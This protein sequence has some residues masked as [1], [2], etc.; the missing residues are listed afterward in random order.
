M[1]NDDVVKQL[2]G[3]KYQVMPPLSQSAQDGLE[4]SIRRLQRLLYPIV[5]DEDGNLLDGH[6]RLYFWHKLKR[7]GMDLE[8]YQVIIVR[9]LSE[10]EKRAYARNLNL[11]RR[12]LSQ[13]ERRELIAQQIKE[14]P[15]KSDRQIAAALGCDHKTVASVREE[16]EGRGEIPHVE[17]RTDSRGRSQPAR[18]PMVFAKNRAEERRARKVL[19]AVPVDSWPDQVIDSRQATRLG[20]KY[21]LDNPPEVPAV[22]TI[23]EAT[24]YHGDL[25]EALSGVPDNSVNLIFCDPP[26]DKE[27]IPV[28]GYLSQLASRILRDDGVLVAYS[29][30]IYLPDIILELGRHMKYHWQLN[31]VH[32]GGSTL[33]NSRFIRSRG[34]PI[35]MYVKKDSNRREKWIDD[36]VKGAGMEKGLHEW[37]QGEPEAMHLIEKLTDPGNLVVDP[38]V[39][40]GTTAA[41]AV[42]LGRRFIG[43]D[44]NPGAVAI[45]QERLAALTREESA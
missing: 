33:V 18:K 22:Q 19:Q 42:R 5:T 31:L 24:L 27:S 38:F 36:L 13:E 26:Y 21:R 20:R 45:T 14:D 43:C 2:P 35:F 28:Y 30:K 9:G 23:G 6:W 1:M 39:G 7:E 40:S 25:L 44:I 32:G 37:Q 11:A 29:G 15:R 41:A 16:L 3:G 12:H 8:P 10:A 34:K 17:A 4:D